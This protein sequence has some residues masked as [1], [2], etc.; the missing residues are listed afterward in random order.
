MGM[1][2][3]PIAPWS[4]GMYKSEI[5]SMR[6]TIRSMELERGAMLQ[7]SMGRI[8]GMMEQI[9]RM[10]K[11]LLGMKEN[12][13]PALQRSMDVNLI[14]YQENRLPLTTVIDSWEALTMM[15]LQVLEE[16]YELSKMIISYEK[17]L[18]R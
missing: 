3:I 7:E 6:S 8:Y 18:Y 1:V 15:Q 16:A 4:S 5:R 14:G 17:E 11:K 10:Q 12:V 13:L 9:R 2:S